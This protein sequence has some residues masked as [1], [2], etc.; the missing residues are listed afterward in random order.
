MI[1]I[2]MIDHVKEKK[3]SQ[4]KTGFEEHQSDC[5]YYCVKRMLDFSASVDD[6]M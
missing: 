3:L 2:T 4:N 1:I 5:Q 6:F